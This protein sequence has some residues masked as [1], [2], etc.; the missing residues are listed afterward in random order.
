[1]NAQAASFAYSI[2]RARRPLPLQAPGAAPFRRWAAAACSAEVAHARDDFWACVHRLGLAA[3]F[4]RDDGFGGHEAPFRYPHEAHA[5]AAVGWLIHLQA[6][7]SDRRAPWATLRWDIWDAARQ[8]HWWN[9]RRRLWAGFLRNVE[10]YRTE[11]RLLG[12]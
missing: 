9:E 4:D 2:R 7:E 10:R 8:R 6:H 11:R 5:F 1:M 12:G 3:R